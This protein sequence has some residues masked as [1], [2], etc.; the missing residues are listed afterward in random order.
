ML[1]V[2]LGLCAALSWG[3]SDFVAGVESRRLSGIVVAFVS[4]GMGVVALALVVLLF[5]GVPDGDGAAAA[6]LAGLTSGLGIALLYSALSIGKMSIVAP[7]AATGGVVPI[8]S[9]MLGGDNPSS[10]QIAGIAAIGAGVLLV[11]QSKE[12]DQA[13]RRASRRSVGV[14]VLAACF[15]GTGLAALDN[16]AES[17]VLSS[18]L[19]AR[20]VGV[21]A[22]GL[23]VVVGYRSRTA[24]VSKRLPTLGLI[25]GLDTSAVLLFALATTKGFLSLVSI[26]TALYPVVT[27]FL[28]RALLAERLRPIQQAGVVLAFTGLALIVAGQ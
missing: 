10:L 19:V 26:A 7:I 2:C 28:A 25:G 15:L 13:S 9:G 24:G 27:V 11:T 14:A 16:A 20:I 5:N 1:A 21:A 8:V 23:I 3:T 18:V 22:L 12:S 4:Q 6:A 17:G